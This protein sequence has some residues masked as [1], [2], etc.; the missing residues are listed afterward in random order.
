L[1]EY[2][3]LISSV[4][5]IEQTA[6][7]LNAVKQEKIAELKALYESYNQSDYQAD[8]WSKLTQIYENGVKTIQNQVNETKV[9]NAFLTVKTA[10]EGV[11]KDGSSNGCGSTANAAQWL[12]LS[13]AIL[14]IIAAKK[15][16][17]RIG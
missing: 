3:A 7:E 12:I 17:K 9:Q 1:A 14:W 4:K 2:T 6:D 16:A 15:R 13:G 11:E 8:T 5:T 10:M